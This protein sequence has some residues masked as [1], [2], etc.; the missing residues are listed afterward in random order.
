[1]KSEPKIK[2]R[3]KA[4]VAPTWDGISYAFG[5]GDVVD[6]PEGLAKDLCRGNVNAELVEEPKKSAT[7]KQPDKIKR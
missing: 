1:M 4:S 3:L 6:V 7:A 5:C 2:I